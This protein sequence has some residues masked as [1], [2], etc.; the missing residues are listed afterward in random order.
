MTEATE[1]T[2]EVDPVDG[3]ETEDETRTDEVIGVAF[4]WSAG[5]IAVAVAFGGVMFWWWG[6]AA[7]EEQVI[8]KETDVVEIRDAVQEGL[9]EIPFRSLTAEESGIDFVHFSGASGDR[10]L[11]ET[12]GGGVALFDFDN[13]ENLDVL[14]VSG[15]PWP[16]DPR[17]ERFTSSLRLYTG[18]GDGSFE[19]VTEAAGLSVELAGMGVAVGDIDNDGWVDLFVTCVGPNRLFRNDRGRFVE[20]TEAAGLGEDDHGWSTAAG[21]FDYDGDGN[22]DLLVGNYVRWDRETDFALNFTLNGV[23]RAYGPPTHYEGTHPTL[24]RGDGEG[25][26]EDVTEAAGLQ[27]THPD[28]GRPFAKTLGLLL[29]DVNRDGWDDVV[30]AN[31]TVRN[32]LFVN[33]GDGTFAETG[34]LSGFAYDRGGMATGAMGIDLASLWDDEGVAIAV[35]NFANEMTSVFV[36]DDWEA[37]FSDEAASLGIGAA[38]RQRLTFGTVFADF[39]LDGRSDLLQ[40]NGHLQ[41]T[42]ADVQPSQSY[43]QPAQLFWNSGATRGV[44]FVDLPADRLGDLVT[45]IVG[46]GAAAGDLDGDGDLDLVVTQIDGPPLVLINEQAMGNGYLRVRLRDRRGN[47]FGYGG[48]VTVEWDDRVSVEYVS[49]TRSYLSQSE[50]IATF[51]FPAGVTRVD[52]VSVAWPGGE[53]SEAWDVTVDQ[54][55]TIE[56]AAAEVSPSDESDVGASDEAAPNGS[57]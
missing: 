18:R 33:G 35:G 13:D 31:D 43:R 40:V 19:D 17:P 53:V 14:F 7:T 4:R 48:R 28:L 5:V 36:A 23:D 37:G 25:R 20:V 52:R 49:P 8:A 38:T 1:E 26:F 16:G 45:P 6:E 46:R 27:V 30:V 10:L 57:D 54:T 12:M 9:P 29:V 56:R 22:L 42:I 3:Y 24:F 44:R 55:L 32:M 41:E 21:F 11:P 34:A 2:R 47:R 51:G 50:P 39:D 15:M